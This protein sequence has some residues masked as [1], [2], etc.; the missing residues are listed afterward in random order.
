MNEQSLLVF[1]YID[2]ESTWTE[3]ASS[4]PTRQT[5]S[6]ED[7]GLFPNLLRSH[8]GTSGSLSGWLAGCL[9]QTLDMGKLMGTYLESN[10]HDGQ[11]VTQLD[12]CYVDNK[13]L[14]M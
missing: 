8:R 3:G 12:G 2:F 1:D 4:D 5:G 11:S 6:K 9:R 7:A 10:L 14:M 13:S